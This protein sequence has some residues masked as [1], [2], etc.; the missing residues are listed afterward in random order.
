MD[1]SK[2]QDIYVRILYCTSLSALDDSAESNYLKKNIDFARLS[3]EQAGRIRNLRT[4]LHSE[5]KFLNLFL[6]KD[7]M[8]P[9]VR[10]YCNSEDFWLHKGRTLLE[11]FCL[12]LCG[13]P[14][15]AKLKFLA[16]VEGT[17]SGV[18]FDQRATTPWPTHKKNLSSGIEYFEGEYYGLLSQFGS[19][20]FLDRLS[21]CRRSPIYTFEVNSGCLIIRVVRRKHE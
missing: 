12:F 8:L 10:S 4:V 9:Y 14:V 5:L 19:D 21:I 7:E 15:D 11:D 1:A 18:S 2:L 6:S 13:Q 3:V 20:N 16:E 17:S